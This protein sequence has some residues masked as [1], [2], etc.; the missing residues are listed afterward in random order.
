[1]SGIETTTTNHLF[2]IT[3]WGVKDQIAIPGETTINYGGNTSCV[4]IKTSKKRLIFDGGTGLKEL[5]NA[6]LKEMPVNAHIFF[7]HFDWD[8]IQGFPFFVPAFI[9][10]NRFYIYGTQT[11]TGL[12]MKEH[13]YK[14]MTGPNF[15]VPIE[16]MG[17]KLEFTEIIPGKNYS[18]KN[19]KIKALILN[20]N[21]NSLGYRVT[22][23]DK[24]V[25]YATERENEG[26]G[27][28]D[29][30]IKLAKNAHL[31]ILPLVAKNWQ[32]IVEIAKL[33][34]VEKIALTA[35]HPDYED[36]LLDQIQQQLQSI[37]SEALIAQEGMTIFI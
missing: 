35:H 20:S 10:G 30:L 15:P 31:L 1:M 4:E 28:R 14:Q 6:M 13:L 27:Y 2:E 23:Q 16:V 33:A 21:Y 25:V 37:H 12:S 3:F 29:N 26:N 18:S 22:Y 19:M 36:H 17:A 7:S 11:K 24:S 8:R 34:E 9:P 32:E 5:G